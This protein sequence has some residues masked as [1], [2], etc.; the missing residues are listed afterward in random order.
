MVLTR[1]NI[2]QEERFRREDVGMIE[3]KAL[4]KLF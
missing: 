3:I 2:H 4:K 1:V